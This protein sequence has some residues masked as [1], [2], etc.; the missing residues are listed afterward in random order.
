[1][2]Y[3]GRRRGTYYR[4]RPARPSTWIR[5]SETI[6]ARIDADQVAAIDLLAPLHTGDAVMKVG[7]QYDA[8]PSATGRTVVRIIGSF[9]I[10]WHITDPVTQFQL[11]DGAW[12]GI[13]V[14][15]WIADTVSETV[16][17][18]AIPNISRRDPNYAANLEDWMFWRHISAF[19]D[20][21]TDSTSDAVG[22]GTDRIF[23]GHFDV[24]AKRNL[25]ELGETPLFCMR[26]AGADTQGIETL[27][28][29]TSTLLR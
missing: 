10:R 29:T 17:I 27:T 26:P 13:V 21:T 4:R 2:P 16:D 8:A 25:R 1:M 19:E 7:G 9:L 12:M 20:Q 3:R 11:N 23:V 22:T 28:V 5:N 15:P 14:L 18:P 24:R 6:S